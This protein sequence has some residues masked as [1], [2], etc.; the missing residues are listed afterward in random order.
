MA[1]RST[2][3]AGRVIRV[4]V[5]VIFRNQRIRAYR[6]RH[7][8]FFGSAVFSRNDAAGRSVQLFPF[9]ERVEVG[10]DDD[11]DEFALVADERGLA[12]EGVDFELAFDGL[13]RDV[14]LRHLVRRHP[15]RD[16]G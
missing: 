6:P 1:R 11:A 2:G 16:A 7:L 12:N 15:R 10:G 5:A 3:K 8:N 4:A 14:R 9:F 13:R